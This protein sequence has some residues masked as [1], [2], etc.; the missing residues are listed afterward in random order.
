MIRR[1]DDQHSQEDSR[2]LIQQRLT[3]LGGPPRLL[4]PR[5]YRNEELCN[6]KVMKNTERCGAV[7]IS[8]GQQG[9]YGMLSSVADN[10]AIQLQFSS[11]SCSLIGLSS[12]GSSQFCRQIQLVVNWKLS[13]RVVG[14]ETATRYR[15]V[16]EKN[17]TLLKVQFLFFFLSLFFGN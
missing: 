17:R 5:P 12:N 9:S 4:F 1:S 6:E 11:I 15:L 14:H 7:S 16:I 8:P 10:N 3:E 2:D 13:I